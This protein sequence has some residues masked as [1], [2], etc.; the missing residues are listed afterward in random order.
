MYSFPDGRTYEGGWR[1]G[2][3][4]GEAKVVSKDG[5]VKCGRFDNGKLVLWYEEGDLQ[6]KLA[7]FMKNKVERQ[8]SIVESKQR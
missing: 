4:H 6:Q 8:K 3:R 7:L 5:T 1:N 2:V